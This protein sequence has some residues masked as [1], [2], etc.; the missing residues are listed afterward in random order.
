MAQAQ[1]LDTQLMQ[2]VGQSGTRGEQVVTNQKVLQDKLCANLNADGTIQSVPVIG[3]LQRGAECPVGVLKA[4]G[5]EVKR[6]VDNMV[7]MVVPVG[8]LT[9][10]EAIDE[11]ILIIPMTKADIYNKEAAASSKASVV[12]TAASATAAGL[13]RNYTG[14]GVVVGIIDRGIDYNHQAFYDAQGKTRVVKIINGP[15]N[16]KEVTEESE[17]VKLTTDHLEKSHGTH[18]SA[19]AVGSEL[20]NGL[21][22]VATEADIIL[23]GTGTKGTDD[24]ICNGIEKIFQYADSKNKPAV[25]NISM[26]TGTNLHDG[27]S[28]ICK[29]INKLTQN[30]SKA[31]RVVV[32]AAGNMADN[33]QSILAKLGTADADG[34]QLK[35][36]MG[37]DIPMREDDDLP[38]YIMLNVFAYAEDGKDFTMELKAVNI[39]TGEV[40]DVASQ[41]MEKPVSGEKY[42]PKVVKGE[43]INIKDEKVVINEIVA[44]DAFFLK[45]QKYRLALFVK[46]TAGQTIKLFR[47]NDNVSEWCFYAPDKLTGYTDGS[48]DFT[49]NADA[50]TDAVISVGAYTTSTEWQDYYDKTKINVPSK[51]TGKEQVLGEIAD[52]S[53]Y[54]VD[55]NGKNRPT[56]IAPG[57]DLLSAI[58]LYDE[59]MFD[60]T[61]EPKTGENSNTAH[62][63]PR[64]MMIEKGGRKNWYGHMGGTSMSSPHVAGIIALWLEANPNLTALQIADIIKETSVKDEFCTDISK[65]PGHNLV[66]AGAGK[67]DAV[68][69]MKKVLELT[70]IRTVDADKRQDADAP[71]YNLMGQKVERSHRGIV[72]SNGRKYVK[73]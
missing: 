59:S 70:G 44:T 55:D 73:K 35:T 24:N 49:F 66:Q 54:C 30:G 42:F 64:S 19:T 13:P 32:M 4:K 20:G 50:C 14:K 72:I 16:N 25:I 2:L 71:G 15:E 43:R 29:T 56:V 67:I 33:K 51:I 34:W 61:G 7:S 17:I 10:F 58:N 65:I 63:C 57:Q 31:G 8:Q 36:A 6:V 3:Y 45:D 37:S 23:V 22:G 52:F 5:I 26:G 9:A 60:A 38:F 28:L 40:S 11:F 53:S 39:E 69:G 41:V 62:I 68:A 47:S 12:N 27:S 1:K 18:T 48:S 21:H 46:G